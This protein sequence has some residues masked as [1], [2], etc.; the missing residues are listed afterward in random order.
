MGQ[1]TCPRY[2]GCQKC[3]GGKKARSG[4]QMRLLGCLEV[5]RGWCFDAL[6]VPGVDTS[7]ADGILRWKEEVIVD[8]LYASRPDVAWRRQVSGS[9]GVKLCS[10][11]L[12]AS[13][14]SSLLRLRLKRLIRRVSGL[15]PLFGG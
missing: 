12:V 1:I 15:G 10:A 9:T 2:T 7:I 4:A 13:S 14:S 6:H 3:P 8:N 11:V 5:G